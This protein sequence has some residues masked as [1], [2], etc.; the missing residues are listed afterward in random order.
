MEGFSITHVF[1]SVL[2]FILIWIA[3]EATKAVKS[4]NA[5]KSELGI[6]KNEQKHHKEILEDHKESIKELKEKLQ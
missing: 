2:G 3:T 4:L 5:V 6:M 1:L